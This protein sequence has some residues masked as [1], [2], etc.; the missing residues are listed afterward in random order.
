M[1]GAESLKEKIILTV[2]EKHMFA[3]TVVGHWSRLSVATEK[4]VSPGSISVTESQL[5]QAIELQNSRLAVM[6]SFYCSHHLSS[7][8][9]LQKR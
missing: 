5:S 9:L 3:K 8:Y 6:L 1:D 7:W 2:C 4:C